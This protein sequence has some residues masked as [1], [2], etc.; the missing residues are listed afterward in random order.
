MSAR[1][2]W[3]D[4]SIKSDSTQ[5]K[6]KKKPMSVSDSLSAK[7]LAY[8]K[9]PSREL[10]RAYDKQ[11]SRYVVGLARR[12]SAEVVNRLK[13][14]RAAGDTANRLVGGEVQSLSRRN[15]PQITKPK[16]KP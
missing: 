4:H 5:T 12:D 13:S 11:A 1:D 2:F 9:K 15:G 14:L 7:E 8:A 16:K 6:P 3:K 10:D